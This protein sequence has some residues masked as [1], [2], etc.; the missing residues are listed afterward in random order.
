MNNK[1]V[2]TTPGGMGGWGGV[3]GVQYLVQEVGA[4]AGQ[5]STVIHYSRD[6]PAERRKD[7]SNYTSH[8]ITGLLG[9]HTIQLPRHILSDRLQKDYDIKSFMTFDFKTFCLGLS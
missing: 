5:R 1:A 3:R 4:M 6:V 9:Q 7:D 8:T 2:N